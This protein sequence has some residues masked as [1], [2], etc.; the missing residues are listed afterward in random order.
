MAASSQGVVIAPPTI[1]DAVAQFIKNVGGTA[2]LAA[3]LLAM[4]SVASEKERGTAGFILTRPAGRDAF[5]VAKLAAV[6]V[7]LLVSMAVAGIGAYVYTAMLFEAPSAIGW[8]VMCLLLWLGQV[9]LAAITLLASTLGRLDGARGGVGFVAYVVLSMLGAFPVLAAWTPQGLVG[10]ATAAALGQ[11]IVDVLSPLVGTTL[12]VVVPSWRRAPSSVARSCSAAVGARARR[13]LRRRELGAAVVDA[14]SRGRGIRSLAR[15]SVR[16]TTTAGQVDD[17]RGKGGV[18][19]G[20]VSARPSSSSVASCSS[21]SA[22]VALAISRATTGGI[23]TYADWPVLGH[24]SI[25]TSPSTVVSV[26]RACGMSNTTL[27]SGPP[28]GASLRR[29]GDERRRSARL[30]RGRSVVRQRD[31]CARTPGGGTGRPAG[32]VP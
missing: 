26:T 31:D 25:S 32:D 1:A 28:H 2:S 21:A 11:P 19:R 3:V 27:L 12:L 6:A 13:G 15:R 23:T 9:A 7:T 24:T 30:V 16:A 29:R 5:I 17:V 18:G 20:P 10:P 14:R 4:G 8:V 22:R